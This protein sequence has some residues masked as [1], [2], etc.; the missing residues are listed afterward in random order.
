MRTIYS[1][2]LRY[3]GIFSASGKRKGKK[4]PCPNESV[5]S[6]VLGWY[7]IVMVSFSHTQ[8]SCPR[9]AAL[10]LSHWLLSNRH[11]KAHWRFSLA[12][13]PWKKSKKGQIHPCQNAQMPAS[14]VNDA[15]NMPWHWLSPC[16]SSSLKNSQPDQ[17]G[18]SGNTECCSLVSFSG[19]KRLLNNISDF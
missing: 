6:D 16:S 3:Q 17:W 10:R 11:I 7:L 8:P 14:L 2:L 1:P 18:Y 5:Q 19:P 4:P 9:R 15:F 12:F 13:S